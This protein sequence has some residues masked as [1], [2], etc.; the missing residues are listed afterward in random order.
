MF[1]NAFRWQHMIKEDMIQGEIPSN[2]AIYKRAFDIA[3]PSTIESILVALIGSVDLMMVGNLGKE[4]IS[5]VGITNQPK[6]I[7]LATIIAL[8]IG[9]TV[10]VSRRKGEKNKEAGNKVLN[11]ALSLSIIISFVLSVLGATFA[12]EFMIFA[13]ATSDYLDLSA[14]Y[15]RIIMIGNFFNCTALTITAAQ[16]GAGN[17]KI[18][19]KTNITANVVNLICN[20]LLINGLF[21]FPKLGVQGAAIATSIGNFVG[22]CVALYS[23]TRKG[24]FLELKFNHLFHFEKS[25]LKEIFNISSASFIEQIFLRIGFFMYAKAVAGL[26]T[27]AFSAHQAVMSIMSISFSVGDGLSIANTSLVGQSLGARRKD[28]A[29][30]YGKVSQR[31]GLM[32]ALLTSLTITIFRSQIMSLFASDPEVIQAGEI[33]LMILSITVIFQISQ[34]IIVGSLR[35]AGDV[36]FVAIIMLISVTIIRPTLTWVLCYP[37]NMGLIGAWLSV[38]LDQLTRYAISLIRF[39]QAKWLGIEV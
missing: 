37:L 33:P 16:R 29:I 31:I 19:M 18:S 5:A 30:I 9:V 12:K 36:K 6:F 32:M 23:V 7:I 21:F 35:G 20:A 4:A 39:K 27:V 38:F 24:K 25:Y 22:F 34:V 13:G 28:M 10:L 14:S 3:W 11:N 15:F 1:L 17:T 8:N 26:G 2:R